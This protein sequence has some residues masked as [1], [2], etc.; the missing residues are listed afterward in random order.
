MPRIIHAR[1]DPDTERLLLRLRRE[2]ALSDSE[3]VRRGLRALGDRQPPRKARAIV[4]LGRF[5]SG[6]SDLGSN[7][8][9]LRGFGRK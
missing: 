2:S 9:H 1:L 5:R 8:S 7:K 4:G 3:L 6:L